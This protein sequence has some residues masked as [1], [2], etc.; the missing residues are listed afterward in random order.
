MSGNTYCKILIES[1]PGKYP[2]NLGQLWT[3]EEV[4]KLLKYVKEGKSQHEI[5]NLHERTVGGIKGK[6]SQ[7]AADYYFNDERSIEQI[8]KFTGLS[9]EE[10]AN[11]ISKRQFQDARK[12]EKQQKQTKEKMMSNQSILPFVTQGPTNTEIMEKLVSLETMMKE[13][14]ELHKEKSKKTIVKSIPK[15]PQTEKLMIINDSS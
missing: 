12:L 7:L 15:S 6:L 8:Q 2:K 10:I 11:S 3:E 4:V 14:L 1:N 9:E 13:I 5:A